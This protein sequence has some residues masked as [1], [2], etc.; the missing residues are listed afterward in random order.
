MTTATPAISAAG[1]RKIFGATVALDGASFEVTAG[2]VHALLG[3][4]GAGKSTMVKLLSGFMRAD[5]GT[6]TAFGKELHFGGPAMPSR[7][8][9]DR[10]SGTDQN[11]NLSAENIRCLISPSTVGLLA[12]ARAPKVAAL[13]DPDHRD[14]ALPRGRPP[15]PALAPEDRD[16]AC[17]L[18]QAPHPAARR[19]DLPALGPGYRRLGADR[20]AEEGGPRSS[21]SPTACRK[22]ASSATIRRWQRP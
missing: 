12:G 20:T 7:R 13:L 8:D 21:S 2:E 16:R 19:A 17:R 3:E 5:A 15:R 9:R 1:V 4:N 18:P 11:L 10:L 6:L 14:R 22:C